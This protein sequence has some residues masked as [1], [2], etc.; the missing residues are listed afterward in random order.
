LRA[1]L[2]EDLLKLLDRDAILITTAGYFTKIIAAIIH[3]RGYDV[4]FYQY[5]SFGS[6]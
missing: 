1:N 4:N 2:L 3:K 6:N 5:Q